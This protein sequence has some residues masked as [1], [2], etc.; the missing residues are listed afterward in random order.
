MLSYARGK[1]LDLISGGRALLHI[2]LD[3]RFVIEL[4]LGVVLED[5]GEAPT[6]GR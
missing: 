3:P 1:E 6:K 4:H 5:C 2:E